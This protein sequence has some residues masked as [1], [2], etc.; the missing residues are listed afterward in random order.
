M[1]LHSHF[2]T[3]I[4]RLP[5]LDAPVRT[6]S[7]GHDWHRFMER[8][9]ITHEG[10]L[11]HVMVPILDT[12]CEVEIEADSDA[13]CYHYRSPSNGRTVTQPL[14]EID[15]FSIQIEPWLDDLAT[16]IGIEDRH[17]D[18]R[19]CRIPHH[20]WHLG[21]L[22]IAGTHDFAPVFVGRAWAHAPAI[23]TTS[24]LADA[25]WP[26]AGVVLQTRRSDV[27][28]PRGHVIRDL[29]E[30]VCTSDGIDTFDAQA[31]DRVLRGYVTASGQSE[32]DQFLQGNRLKLPHFTASRT[33]PEKQAKIIREM[34][35][36]LGQPAPV[37][38]W[39]E[40]NGRASVA[41]GYQS[42]DDAFGG[43]AE[44]EDIIAQIKRGKYQIRR[45]P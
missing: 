11:T 36:T 18:H 45:N 30:F 28:L 20:L 34:W 19:P 32:P 2:F 3:A 12:E 15:L 29:N 6:A 37:L 26:R 33:L 9:W 10:H 38:S 44:R 21:D 40:V 17:R 31:F 13:D 39:A 24:A 4:D 14:C 35:G 1:S 27:T 43:K 16:V 22:R 7:L 25:L 42:F 8:G 23:D 5:D 41:T